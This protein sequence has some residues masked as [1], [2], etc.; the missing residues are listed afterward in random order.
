MN[1]VLQGR[2]WVYLNFKKKKEVDL[3]LGQY[4]NYL[5]FDI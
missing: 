5:S 4:Q 3:G 2:G 1:V